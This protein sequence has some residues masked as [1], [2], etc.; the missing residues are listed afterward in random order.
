V[1]IPAFSFFPRVASV[2]LPFFLGALRAGCAPDSGF[3]DT[4][5]F[6]IRGYLNRNG[7]VNMPVCVSTS[8]YVR[9]EELIGYPPDLAP[10]AVKVLRQA[11]ALAV[12]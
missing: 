5:G 10:E 3:L 8:L 7:R 1:L 9:K 4:W 2:C 12:V 6:D 11:A